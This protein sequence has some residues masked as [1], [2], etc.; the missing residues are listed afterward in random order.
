MKSTARPAVVVVGAFHARTVRGPNANGH[1][2]WRIDEGA[3]EG[4][5]VSHGA[6]WWSRAEVEVV[7]AN[8]ALGKV[9]SAESA[10]MTVKDLMELYVGSLDAR[11]LK[12]RTKTTI[13]NFARHIV[14]VIGRQLVVHITRAK[15]EEYVHLRLAEPARTTGRAAGRPT[16]RGCAPQSIHREVKVLKTAWR[17]GQEEGLIEDQRP[18]RAPRL[19]LSTDPVRNRHTPSREDIERV[20]QDITH[21][22]G[23]GSWQEIAFWLLAE[24]GM[25]LGEA[26]ELTWD[27]VNLSGRFLEVNGKMGRRTVPITWSLFEYLSDLPRPEEGTPD[28]PV[29]PGGVTRTSRMLMTL[30]RSCLRAKVRLFNPGGLR[31]AAVDALYRS[32]ADPSVAGAIIGHSPTV[33]MRHYRSID[34]TARLAAMETALSAPGR[35]RPVTTRSQPAAA[36]S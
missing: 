34:V 11:P 2:Y 17:W 27:R 9:S 7:V 10:G 12:A 18:M 20:S 30:K 28:E 6:G 19:R 13:T 35:W 16:A 14:R 23:A 22:F 33:A 29:V 24:T 1:W 5:R 21:Q 32:G 8:M 3:G 26:F 36:R 31:R 15:L 25:R 4:L